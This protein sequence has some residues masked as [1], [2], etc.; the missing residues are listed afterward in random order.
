MFEFQVDISLEMINVFIS[1]KLDGKMN[2]KNWRIFLPKTKWTMVRGCR[3]KKNINISLSL[4]LLPSYLLMQLQL[5]SSVPPVP[6][7]WPES[8]RSLLST[9]SIIIFTFKSSAEPEQTW[10]SK[11]FLVLQSFYNFLIKLKVS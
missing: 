7:P 5:C 1:V 11:L 2:V 10:I 4:S 8:A 9:N 6:P 3:D